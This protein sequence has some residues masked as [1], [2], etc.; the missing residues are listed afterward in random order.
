MI[1][2]AE[3][4]RI[5]QEEEIRVK[6]RRATE[7]WMEARLALVGLVIIVIGS[8]VIWWLFTSQ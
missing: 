3:R 5:A 2:E 6:A 4:Q 8:A 1:S 7:V